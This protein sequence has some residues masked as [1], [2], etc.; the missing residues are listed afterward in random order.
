M[1]VCLLNVTFKKTKKLGFQLTIML[2]FE[3]FAIK[4]EFVA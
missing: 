2:G 1:L 3:V 4:P